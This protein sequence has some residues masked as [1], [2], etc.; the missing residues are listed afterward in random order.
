MGVSYNPKI[1][2]DD[3]VAVI[4]ARNPKCVTSSTT[5]I[6]NYVSFGGNV[7][8]FTGSGLKVLLDSDAGNVISLEGGAFTASSNP[9]INKYSYS[10][11]CWIKY[12]AGK[13]ANYTNV[14]EFDTSDNP[15]FGYYM[16]CDT[17][18]TSSPSI[19]FFVKDHATNSWATDSIITNAEWEN[20]TTWF[21]IAV[22]QA[23]ESE[24]KTYLNGKLHSTVSTSS[25]DLSDYGDIDQ[26]QIGSSSNSGAR[27]GHFSVYKKVL[28]ASEIKENFEAMRGRFNI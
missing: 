11:I 5:K 19:L 14:W 9:F 10:V 3:L 1:V 23:Q 2:S 8:D 28:T 25:Q 18:T 7:Q 16:R 21:C 24:F 27:L 22:T 26:V 15:S 4:D 20:S 6:N 13:N 17:R 12:Q